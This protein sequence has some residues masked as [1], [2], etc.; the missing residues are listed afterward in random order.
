MLGQG[1]PIS[2]SVAQTF[3]PHKRMCKRSDSVVL[4]LRSFMNL[5]SRS[6]LTAEQALNVWKMESVTSLAHMLRSSWH[7]EALPAQ[8][9]SCPVTLSAAWM[10]TS[11]TSKA[12]RMHSYRQ[13]PSLGID[14]TRVPVRLNRVSTAVRAFTAG[15]LGAF[16]VARLF[17]RHDVF[18]F[19]QA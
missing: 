11:W 12:R 9:R 5:H 6:P 14:I 2:N 3:P 13:S 10:F 17:V 1:V 8:K 19:G 15:A 16:K 4:M 7:T 18:F